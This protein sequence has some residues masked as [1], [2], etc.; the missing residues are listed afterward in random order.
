[1][2]YMYGT[3]V[4][5]FCSENRLS[6]I[7]FSNPFPEK[8]SDCESQKSGFEFDANNPPGVW[9]LWIHDPFLDLSKK[10]QNLFLDSET[11]GFGFFPKN[12]PN[13][14][15]TLQRS[16]ALKIVVANRLL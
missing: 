11:D 14:A 8:R 1:M 6:K 7:L 15:S 13:V 16:D 3:L 9:I 4:Y 12:A 2:P 5:H 10:T